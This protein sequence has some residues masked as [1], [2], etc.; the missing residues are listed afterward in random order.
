PSEASAD[1]AQHLAALWRDPELRLVDVL[2]G[3]QRRAPD[4]RHEI[5]P[6]VEV[7]VRHGDRVQRRP[8]LMLAELCEDARP[9]V[10]QQPPR[11]FE[12]VAGLSA[13]GVRPRG[14]AAY[15]G[16][17]HAHIL[18]R[19]PARFVSSLQ[20]PV[21]TATTGARRSSHARSVMRAWRSSTPDCTR[22]PSRLSR[23]RSRRTPTRSG[24]RSSPART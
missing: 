22:R 8:A 20:S 18:T 5:A 15:D 3:A 11:A 17:F 21:L 19:W 7:P 14:R 9:A 10:E 6:V 24:S 23:P 4:P 2:P 16:Q 1:R 13:A 12:E